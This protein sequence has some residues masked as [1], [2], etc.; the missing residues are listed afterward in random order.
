MCLFGWSWCRQGP[1]KRSTEKWK[2]SL[3]SCAWYWCKWR[4]NYTNSNT[5]RP[6][7]SPSLAAFL[8]RLHQERKNLPPFYEGARG[9]RRKPNWG[10]RG[11]A[12]VR[13]FVMQMGQPRIHR[14][15]WCN[16]ISTA[17]V[18][19]NLTEHVIGNSRQQSFSRRAEIHICP[20]QE[21][22]GWHLAQ[23]HSKGQVS[24]P[25]ANPMCWPCLPTGTQFLVVKHDW[26]K[27]FCIPLTE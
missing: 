8:C 26:F 21:T 18:L 20:S 17:F 1:K 12:T 6:F 23:I 10:V 16:S 9:L 11:M 2:M 22:K 25:L 7:I 27:I 19:R 13:A 14:W 3:G 5:I 24:T 15:C 4:W